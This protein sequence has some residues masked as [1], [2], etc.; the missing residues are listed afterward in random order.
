MSKEVVV[1]EATESAENKFKTIV[2]WKIG[3]HFINQDNIR[4]LSRKGIGRG[5]AIRMYHGEDIRVNVDYDK[6]ISM[7]PDTNK[8]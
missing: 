2:W 4:S 1:P 3:K 8:I 5:T 6:L 7:L